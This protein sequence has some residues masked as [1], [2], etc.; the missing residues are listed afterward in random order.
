MPIIKLNIAYDGTHYCGW[1]RQ[2]A[3]HTSSAS[4]QSL[5]TSHQK[6]TIQETIE[7][8][9]QKIFK[10][11]IKV[12]GSGR[13]DAGV[14]ALAQVAHF[15]L[16]KPFDITKLAS[17]VNAYLPKDISVI[18]AEEAVKGFHSRFCA[19]RKIYRYCIANSAAKPLFVRHLSSWVRYPISIAKMRR[20]SKFL[21]GRHDFK[22]FQ[23]SDR[24]IRKSITHIYKIGIKKSRGSGLFPFIGV[25]NWVVIDIEASGFLRNMV[26][27]IVGTLVE[28]G[29]GRIKPQDV[30]NI[31]TKKDRR[32]AGPCAPAAGL[33]LMD[34]RYG[35]L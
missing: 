10:K 13:T 5:A 8:A 35:R 34:V 30:K 18:S 21:L 1:Q 17:A 28:V 32:S 29:R 31:L 4:H 20:A 12:E 9:L 7:D 24:V 27:N 2:T 16:D 6:K 23:A 11:K 3:R 22:S 19:Q 26:R 25:S 15:K 33:Y 14:H